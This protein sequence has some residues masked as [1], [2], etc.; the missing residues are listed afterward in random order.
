MIEKQI[1]TAIWIL[2]SIGCLMSSLPKEVNG[3][4]RTALRVLTAG[5]HHVAFERHYGQVLVAPQCRIRSSSYFFTAL[6]LTRI[7]APSGPP[8]HRAKRELREWRLSQ[9]AKSPIPSFL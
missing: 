4:N 6:N 8:R 5:I 3:D 1:A 7:V 2:H 9:T